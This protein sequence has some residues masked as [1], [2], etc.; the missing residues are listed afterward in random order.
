MKKTRLAAFCILGATVA[1][2]S[3][4]MILLGAPAVTGNTAEVTRPIAEA[5]VP[6]KDP[7]EMPTVHQDQ[8]AEVALLPVPEAPLPDTVYVLEDGTLAT[9][10]PALLA[11]QTSAA[12]ENASALP[13]GSIRAQFTV[14]PTRIIV[15][16]RAGKI[17]EIWNNVLP[18]QEVYCLTVKEKGPAGERETGLTPAIVEAYNALLPRIDWAEQGMVFPLD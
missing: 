15:V 14:I 6:L 8:T 10:M 9:E 3:L 11:G 5:D 7:E 1:T 18:G 2:T 16:D 12:S 13:G 17:T 4:G